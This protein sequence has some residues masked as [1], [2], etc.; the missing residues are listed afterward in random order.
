MKS[1]FLGKD[2]FIWWKGV[3]EDRKDPIMLGRVKVRIF[4]WHSEDKQ[5]IPPE[6]LPW[7]IPSVQYDAVWQIFNGRVF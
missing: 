3:V 4:G 5:K 2:Q 7:A 6:E 1:K